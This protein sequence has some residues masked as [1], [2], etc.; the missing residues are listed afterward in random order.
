MNPAASIVI[1]LKAQRDEWLKRCVQSAAAQTAPCEVIVIRA[2]STPP[3][4]LETLHA[5]QIQRPNIH[6]LLEDK[7]GSFPAAI[8]LGIRSAIAPR[9]GLLLSDD[10]LEKDA[11]EHCLL[12]SADIV[13]TGLKTYL[14]DGITVHER[15][16]RLLTMN[17]YRTL[18]SF[19]AQAVYLQHFFLFRKTVVIDAGGLDETIGNFP[20]IDDYD[21][22]WTLLERGASV[23][24]VER[25]LYSYRDHPGERLT[26]ADPVQA[27]TNL[28]KI[29]RKHLLPEA[30]M[31]QVLHE[32]SRW[33]GRTIHEVLA[34]M[35]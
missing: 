5:L 16:S 24:I 1:P 35:E 33:Y 30:E 20:G 19:Q 7:P 34:E 14:E 23:A 4:N 10:W 15:A 8:N 26:L 29:L 22:I 18:K 13:S 25:Y 11:V 21:L 28:K 2:E 3:S 17:E 9:V 31:S 32:H 27:V 6:V 12:E